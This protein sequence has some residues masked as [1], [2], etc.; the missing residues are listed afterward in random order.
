MRLL[1]TRP[2]D[3]AARTAERL[4]A[5]GNEPVLA[6]VLEIAPTGADVPQGPFDLVLATSAQA[7]LAGA[8]PLAPLVCVG[9]KTATAGRAAGFAVA[10]VASDADKLAAA[11]LRDP[12][13]RHVLYLAGQERKPQLEQRLRAACWRVDV[14]E[15]YAARPVHAWPEAIGSALLAGGIDGALHYSPRSAELSLRLMGEAAPRLAHFCLSPAVATVCRGQA[16]PDKIF[17]ASHPDEDSL[18]TVVQ[19]QNALLGDPKP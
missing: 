9:E 12:L 1:V 3:Q 11:L 17:V 7:F 8:A 14:A 5:L 6:P 2:S 16:P 18:L 10:L 15:T 13:P 4:R 19:E